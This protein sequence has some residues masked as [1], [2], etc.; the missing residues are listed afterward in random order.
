MYLHGVQLLLYNIIIVGAGVGCWFL[1]LVEFGAGVG[2]WFLLLVQVLRGGSSGGV[3]GG[4]GFFLRWFFF[5]SGF[6]QC[7]FLVFIK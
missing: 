1:L 6:F 7:I 4:G 2:C 5:T 3:G